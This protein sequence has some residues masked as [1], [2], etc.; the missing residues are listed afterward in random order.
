MRITKVKVEG[1]SKDGK[2]REGM[3]L[4]QREVEKSSLILDKFSPNQKRQNQPNDLTSEIIDK[5]KNR[6]F[7]LSLLKQTLTSKGN[8]GKGQNGQLP[9]YKLERIIKDLVKAAIYN[10]YIDSNQYSK[11]LSDLKEYRKELP[12]YIS[13]KFREELKYIDAQD[14]P[15]TLNLVACLQKAVDSGNITDLFSYKEWAVAYLKRKKAML[16]KSIRNNRIATNSIPTDEALPPSKRRQALLL[17][18]K[19]YEKNIISTKAEK[20]TDKKEPTKYIDLDDFYKRF[21]I[22]ELCKSLLAT[23]NKEFEMLKENLQKKAKDKGNL[24]KPFHVGVPIM[25]S[26]V[27]AALK[28]TL[29]THQTTVFGKST[30]VAEGSDHALRATFKTNREDCQLY[31]YNL[32][33]VKYMEHYFPIK[34]K[35]ILPTQKQAEY[36]LNVNTI[37]SRI[38]F[39]LENALRMQAIQQ[40]KL[41]HHDLGKEVN[42]NLLASIKRDEFF[43]LN[44]IEACFFATSNL[45]NI[46]KK[47]SNDDILG[48]KCFSSALENMSTFDEELCRLFFGESFKDNKQALWAMRGAIQQI[49]NN[50]VHYK[51]DSITK[52]FNINDFEYPGGKDKQASYADTPFKSMLQESSEHIADHYLEQLRSNNVLRFYDVKHLKEFFGAHSLSLHRSSVPFAPGFKNVYKTGANL[53]ETNRNLRLKN[54][55]LKADNG[56][57]VAQPKSQ[58]SSSATLPPSQTK[59]SPA[60]DS[61]RFILKLI[62]NHVFLKQFLDSSNQSQFKEVVN[63]VLDQNK[64]N[65]NG[66]KYAFKEIRHMA[67]NE[68]AADYMSYVHS[69]FVQEEEKKESQQKIKGDDVRNNASKF[70]N[71]VFIKGFDNFLSTLG[72]SFLHTPCLDNQN[73]EKEDEDYEAIEIKVASRLDSNENCQIA[74][75]TFCKLLDNNHLSDLRNELLKYAATSKEMESQKKDHFA[76]DIIELCILENDKFITF[77]DEKCKSLPDTEKE[78]D[79]TSEISYQRFLSPYIS[80]EQQSDNCVWKELYYQ[81]DN[82][83]SVNYASIALIRK[84][85]TQKLLEEVI[86]VDAKI[87]EENY[88]EWKQLKS[89]IDEKMNRREELHAAW[90]KAKDHRTK[91]SK[92]TFNNTEKEDKK[93]E[94]AEKKVYLDLCKEIERYNWLDNKL[95]LVHLKTLHNLVIQILSRMA[96]F[97]ALW[98]RDFVLMDAS[99]TEDTYRLTSFV[100]IT[101]LSDSSFQ[102]NKGIIKR[103]KKDIISRNSEFNINSEFKEIEQC[104]KSKLAYYEKSFNLTEA[105]VETRDTIAH[106][107]Y[108]SQF[109]PEKKSETDDCQVVGNEAISQIISKKQP[110]YKQAPESVSLIELINRLRSLMAYDRKLRNTVSK[111]IINVFKQNGME[112]KFKFKYSDYDSNEKNHLLEVES[113]TSQKIMLLKGSK[114]VEGG[115]KISLSID[116]VSE[117]YCKLCKRLLELKK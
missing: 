37:K 105:N 49:R 70:I 50:V 32:E 112:L 107:G 109:F 78:T 76:F 28:K 40:G 3:V 8:F 114:I 84:F 106:Y 90:E 79:K 64:E 11:D 89:K 98:D 23:L 103:N 57:Q 73:R 9:Y 5:Y 88:R 2:K 101:N 117:E 94:D 48:K 1:A 18:Q 41:N 59:L 4:L 47:E 61:F 91:K 55:L 85:G 65:A 80:G 14:K 95:H 74:F 56:A 71:Q 67:D 43:M 31:A 44:F 102:D 96:R 52:V 60:Y 72:I 30:E 13:R 58:G 81:T 92:N 42:S 62:Y 39:Q 108:I 29:Q 113:V 6:S 100:N 116:Q 33:V 86:T 35:K 104:L 10:K 46:I 99:R 93:K 54:F 21:N 34:R 68:N 19:E 110:K 111:S 75:F 115:K 36:Y 66:E 87:T 17:W 53:Q 12:Y 24:A 25:T 38:Q 22:E 97:V 27:C 26:N 63:F 15:Q 51:K 83:T 45:R 7:E 69:T 16:K 82:K 77:K 20:A